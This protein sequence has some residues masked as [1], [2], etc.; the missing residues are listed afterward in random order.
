MNQVTHF[1]DGSAVYGST[2]EEELE[3]REGTGGL[4]KTQREGLLPPN[5]NIKEEDCFLAGTGLH[6]FRA[7]TVI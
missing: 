6:C 2:E 3:L 4:L 7:G 5:T 1:L